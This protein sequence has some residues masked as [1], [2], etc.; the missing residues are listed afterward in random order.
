MANIGAGET[1]NAYLIKKENVTVVDSMLSDTY[2]GD[3]NAV[4]EYMTPFQYR[5]LS[6]KEMA[7]FPISNHLKGKFDG[8]IFTSD[9]DLKPRQ[10]DKILFIDGY[11]EGKR[12]LITKVLPQVQM[13]M[14][15]ISKKF[16]LII[17]LT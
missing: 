3:T 13:G 10:N 8:V 7:Y 5:F 6:A 4:Y 9:F 1:Y 2:T 14:F 17:E 11:L 15:V 12:T 16:P